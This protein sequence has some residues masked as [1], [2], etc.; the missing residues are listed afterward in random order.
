[1]NF[2]KL[3]ELGEW[4]AYGFYE[5]L[6]QPWP[7]AYGRAYRRLYE[8]MPI[9]VLPD[10]LLV[11]C[12]PLPF[13]KTRE[14]HDTW[15]AT[16]LICDFDHNK[17][18]RVNAGIA[19]ERKRQY[20]EHAD[21]I[22]H[23]VEDLQFRLPHFGGYTHSNPD[24]RRLLMDG[25]GMMVAELDEQFV[26]LKQEKNPDPNELSLMIA[27]KDYTAGV[28]AFYERTKIEL[29]KAVAEAT[30][31]HRN[32]LEIILQHYE[33]AFMEPCNS[34]I[35]GLLSIHF[36]WMLDGHDSL[37][38]IDQVLGIFFEN[39]LAAGKLD[40][41]FARRLI[42]EMWKNF[43]RFNGWNIQIGGFT[44]E[45]EDGCNK[46]T[47]ECIAACER[48]HF[49][50]PN[51]AF[52]VTQDTPDKYLEQA[53]KALKNGSGRPALYNDDLYVKSLYEMDL[54]LTQEDA[55]EIGF[56]GCT[57]TMIAGLS[58]VGSL[59]G[60]LN[61]AK[62]LELALYD[63]F[64]HS[65]NEQWGP[66]TGRF[67]E[68]S[69][70][71][72]FGLAVKRQIQYMTDSFVGC[73]NEA[74]KKRFE[75]GDP[76][77]YR[78]FFTRDCVRKR[79]SFEGGGARYNWS[80]ISYQGIANMIDS[81]AAIKKNVFE[82]AVITQQELIDAL[83]ADFAGHEC[84]RQ[85]LLNAPKFGNDEPYVDD[86]G[87]EFVEFAWDELYSHSP[88]RGGRY[89]PSCILFVTYYGAGLTVGPTPDGRKNGDVLTDSIG[90]AAGKD[91]SGPTSLLKSVSKLPL[92]KAIGTP[93]L[94]LRFQ[95]QVLSTEN[96][97]DRIISLI[98][99]FFR[100]GG[101]QVQFSVLS[102]E[103]MLEAQKKPA[104]HKDLIVRIGGYSEYFVH[105]AP[106]LQQSVIDRTE[107]A[108]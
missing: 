13:A 42:D 85:L 8:E 70:F 107:H 104:Q 1:M 47:T 29:R 35:G 24:I 106:E 16:S 26:I 96:G 30:G 66:H 94:N 34:F 105:L 59:D 17:G 14:S 74:L 4:A 88:P 28:T 32:D 41:D 25:F 37:G 52:R 62:A 39:D 101:L 98:R 45:G 81:L 65:R 80:V 78:T 67:A 87:A 2:E 99:S 9:R 43:E 12:E 84:I 56:G 53:L 49:R 68:F 46:L 3:K 51:L 20:P 64:D 7:Q 18:L 102:R 58:N 103:E 22:D 5:A 21:F 90:A 95:K 92:Y 89:L 55:R 31:K 54:G 15:Y 57:E 108:V 86:L 38:R 71:T 77:L 91:V 10:R 50:R 27:L 44:P 11:P 23:L 79:R 19:E 69:T 33:H 76:K 61:L 97:L 93:V 48:N 40:I 75:Q 83:R 82:D 100:M 36:A 60:H 73:M 72:E 6:R 63:G